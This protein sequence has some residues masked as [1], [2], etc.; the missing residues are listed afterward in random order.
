MLRCEDCG[1]ESRDDDRGWIVVLLEKD[2][3]NPKREALTY[4]P[5]CAR[6]FED[7]PPQSFA[8]PR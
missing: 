6:Q 1:R 4:C 7:E 2:A 3:Y 8:S 5:D